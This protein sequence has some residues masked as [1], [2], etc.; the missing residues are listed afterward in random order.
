MPFHREC[1]RRLK[2]SKILAVRDQNSGPA[3]EIMGI[4]VEHVPFAELNDAWK[5][6]DKDEARAVAD[7]WTKAAKK[8]EGVS[9]RNA[10]NLR[11]DVSGAKRPC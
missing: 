1:L 5:Q 8:I 3:G 4:K 7:R 6:A 10:R 9:A 11:G 2:E